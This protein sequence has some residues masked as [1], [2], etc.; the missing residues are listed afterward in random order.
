[1][2]QLDGVSPHRESKT[3]DGTARPESRP[4]GKAKYSL[5]VSGRGCFVGFLIV[6]SGSARIDCWFRLGEFIGTT[7]LPKDTVMTDTHRD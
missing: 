6:I 2:G 3:L 5:L 7:L 1:M 4:T